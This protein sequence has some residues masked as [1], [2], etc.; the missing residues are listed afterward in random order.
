MS[1]QRTE[2]LDAAKK[3]LKLSSVKDCFSLSSLVQLAS[4]VADFDDNNKKYNG[5]GDRPTD[6]PS[7]TGTTAA[8]RDAAELRSAEQDAVSYERRD[9][10]DDGGVGGGGGGDD[11]DDDGNQ[12]EKQRAA[13]EPAREQASDTESDQVIEL[14]PGPK[15]PDRR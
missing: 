7:A 1:R 5:S 14:V 15:D 10:G 9:D 6:R 4:A 13:S 12:D 8:R 2:T 3:T 11:D